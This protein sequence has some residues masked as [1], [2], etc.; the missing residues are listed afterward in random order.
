MAVLP[1]L[2]LLTPLIPYFVC[3]PSVVYWALYPYAPVAVIVFFCLA[4]VPL[5]FVGSLL[6][7]RYHNR[8]EAA[9]LGAVL[10]PFVQDSSWLGRGVM[11]AM[12]TDFD[13]GYI[14]D[15]FF[16]WSYKYGWTMGLSV[17]L[18]DRIHT[19][20]P[21]Y[22]KAI[23]ASNFQGFMKGPQGRFQLRQMLGDGVFNSDDDTWKF[24]RGMTRPF[25]SRERISDFETF[26][27]HTQKALSV[28][29]A[30]LQEGHAIDFQDLVSRFT[31]DAATDFL[32]GADMQSLSADIP[33]PHTH[34][35]LAARP[36]NAHPNDV[37]ANAFLEAQTSLARRSRYG[38]AWPL[39]ELFDNGVEKNMTVIRAFVDPIVARAVE[40]ADS[41]HMGEKTEKVEVEEGETL[42]DHLAKSTRDTTLLRD[43]TLNILL[44]GRDTTA[45][46]LS[47][48]IYALTQNPS[49][50]ARLREE[51]L[52]V[53]GPTRA[54]TPDDIRACKFV[55][56][57][58]NETMRLWPP[59]PFNGRR[60][61]EPTVWPATTPGGK[62]LYI[63]ADTRC[64]YSVMMM[65]RRTDLWGPDALTFDPDRWLD[66]RLKI[67]TANPF[68]FLPFNAG[69]R[70]CLGQQGR[71][72]LWLKSHLTSY[73]K[74]GVWVRMDAVESS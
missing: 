16:E 2:Q 15:H 5:T 57:V 72:K 22:I 38:L 39:F 8:R 21:E 66:D 20:E 51:I 28:L 18:E 33:Y 36:P 7:R 53:V 47:S 9:R 1:V 17:M 37:F 64:T 19:S 3:P 27:Q 43:E 34:T 12:L 48:A 54:P 70:I 29:R 58:L 74:G 42:L 45:S 14:G 46:L 26:E 11:K 4:S 23:L 73:W 63:P 65:H 61:R 31:I 49:I 67:L 13:E 59:V 52:S 6:Y 69:P 32:F 41:G 30:R 44:A 35:P 60:S 62:P 10:P 71:E 68:I 24:H 50:F 55:R 56:A 40:Q 25:F